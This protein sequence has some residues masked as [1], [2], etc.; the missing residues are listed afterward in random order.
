MNNKKAELLMASV[1][2]A[3]GSSYLL[4]KVGLNSISPFNL[5]ALRFGIAFI[6]MTLLFHKHF[7]KLTVSILRK[8]LL[9]GIILFLVF[10]G[11][12]CGV[13][14]T[15]ASAAGF[16][17]STTVI[18]VPILECIIRKKLPQGKIIFS[19]LLVMIG[20][21]FLTVQENVA[22]DAGAI[23]CLFGALSYA[24]YIIVMDKIAKEEDTLLISILQLGVASFL[25]ILFMILFEIPHLPATPLQWAAII[26]LGLLCSAYGFVVQPIAQ[27]HTSPER[28][29]L[30]FSLEPVFSAI[31]SYIFLHETLGIKGYIGAVL[32]FGGVVFSKL[33]SPNYS[34]TQ[35]KKETG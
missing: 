6:F 12:V 20:L 34:N 26:C 21:Y 22:I 28:I 2:L 7:K 35:I 1:A 17:T 16:L 19:V 3:W 27:K 13:N 5:I 32:V 31:L 14:H 29:G 11:M 8:G 9:M 24:V 23:Y 4:M 25:G 10:T 18:L 30:I 15:T 33:K